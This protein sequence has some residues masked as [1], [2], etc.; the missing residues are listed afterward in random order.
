MSIEMISSII[1]DF[2]PLF[3]D[4]IFFLASMKVLLDYSSID[5]VIRIILCQVDIGV[6][7]MFVVRRIILA[8]F[9]LDVTSSTMMICTLGSP[10]TSTRLFDLFFL[11]Y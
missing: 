11:K 6:F 2:G 8:M 3:D 4:D 10:A 1:S 7:L 9:V 5:T